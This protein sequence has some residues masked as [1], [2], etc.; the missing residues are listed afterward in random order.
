MRTVWQ[1]VGMFGRKHNLEDQLRYLGQLYDR[2]GADPRV[3]R[4][5]DRAAA[6]PR[7]FAGYDVGERGRL[8]QAGHMARL[9]RDTPDR[10]P[11]DLKREADHALALAILTGLNHPDRLLVRMAF[12][13]GRRRLTKVQIARKL[14]VC[15]LTV[16]HRLRAILATVRIRADR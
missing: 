12:G 2:Y 13:I 8:P 15:T 3:A 11:Y 9:R 5:L 7:L 16:S 6:S 4:I 14:G 1:M 10:K